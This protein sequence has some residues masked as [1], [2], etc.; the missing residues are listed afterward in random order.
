MFNRPIRWGCIRHIHSTRKGIIP[1]QFR[2]SV[3]VERTVPTMGIRSPD[4]T[5]TSTESLIDTTE[6]P[7]EA[8]ASIK[9]LP[10]AQPLLSKAPVLNLGKNNHMHTTPNSRHQ[11]IKQQLQLHKFNVITTY[12]MKSSKHEVP[13]ATY[14]LILNTLGKGTYGDVLELALVSYDRLMNYHIQNKKLIEPLTPSEKY[15]CSCDL[16]KSMKHCSSLLQLG[17]LNLLHEKHIAF[18]PDEHHQL[19]ELYHLAYV[20]I[21]LNTNQINHALEYVDLLPNI[22]PS[23][24]D[25]IFRELIATQN[26][27]K[28]VEYIPKFPI[29]NDLW[30]SFL[31]LGILTCHYELVKIVYD[32]HIMSGF[33][34][35]SISTEQVV[36]E[37]TTNEIV[38]TLTNELIYQILHVLSI[39]G[40][41]NLTLSLVESHFLHK[42]F[43]GEK[44]LTKELC[45]KIIDAYCYHN[46]PVENLPT[47]DESD[48]SV[49]RV[50][51]VL[52]GFVTRFEKNGTTLSY[53]DV[54]LSMSMKFLNYRIYDE[55]IA[56]TLAKREHISQLIKESEEN[57]WNNVL[58]PRKFTNENINIS[59]YGN[60]L[61]NLTILQD[62][63]TKHIDYLMA[64]KFHAQ[65]I[66]V[67]INC[68]LNHINLYQNFSAS[69]Q[70]LSILHNKNATFLDWLNEELFD[71]LLKTLGNTS[72]R[73]SAMIL[74][75]YLLDRYKVLPA[76]WYIY[77]MSSLRG[78][79]DSLQVLLF[80]HLSIGEC[81]RQVQEYLTLIGEDC[82][83]QIINLK[84]DVH[85]FWK[86]N[87]FCKEVKQI[88]FD[89]VVDNGKRYYKEYD[90]RDSG[91]LKGI[92]TGNV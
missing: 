43:K 71:I 59:K 75:E 66:T 88:D 19:Q 25:R 50:L 3:D 49:Q 24:G 42:S 23:L 84:E 48:N 18:I 37:V 79:Q 9:V 46:D 20:G 13:I 5:N 57:E 62:F 68:V 64:P 61:S 41:V 53:K 52:N 83:N 72:G 35:S 1:S 32:T 36:T 45:L 2:R 54:T 38:P 14:K 12:L 63:V 11:H 26:C 44:A 21:L 4:G 55:N 16:L 82:Y 73:R 17:Q 67:F 89:K 40:D 27:D 47:I 85:V 76:K 30:I 22:L 81:D 33:E 60:V 6:K 15:H 28:I 58:L 74:F 80:Q 77:L 92:F 8:E 86:D 65:T 10:K 87:S 91:Y 78:D 7:L 56:N 90:D 70:V 34:N 29:S 69:V 51:D 39:S 31:S